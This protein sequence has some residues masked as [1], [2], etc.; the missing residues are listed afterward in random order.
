MENEL[1]WAAKNVETAQLYQD[2]EEML[3]HNG[4]QAIV[5]ASATSVHAEQAIKAINKGLHVL[6]E[7][8]LST[9]VE[10]VRLG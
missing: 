9:N 3:E 1:K 6:C 2:F 7:K 4:L 10:V 8:P 5:I